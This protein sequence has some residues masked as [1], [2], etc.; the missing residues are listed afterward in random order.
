MPAAALLPQVLSVLVIS[1]GCYIHGSSVVF[2]IFA[3][4]GLETESKTLLNST[5][6]NQTVLGFSYDPVRDSAWISKNSFLRIQLIDIITL[7]LDTSM[8]IKVN[9]NVFKNFT[10]QNFSNT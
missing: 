2:G 4:I 10:I 1:F 6:S 7:Q 5:T 8:I 9:D 3:T